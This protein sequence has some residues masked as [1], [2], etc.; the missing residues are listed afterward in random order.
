MEATKGKVVN[1]YSGEGQINTHM[2]YFYL[3]KLIRDDW[4]KEIEWQKV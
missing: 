1:C 4:L 2:K 3:I